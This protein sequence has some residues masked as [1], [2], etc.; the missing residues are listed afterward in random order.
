[1]VL[2]A[3][4]SCLETERTRDAASGANSPLSLLCLTRQLDLPVAEITGVED[5]ICA[6]QEE[7]C[8]LNAPFPFS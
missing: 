5:A 7:I 4:P 2:T 6:G 1:M 3:A 8:T